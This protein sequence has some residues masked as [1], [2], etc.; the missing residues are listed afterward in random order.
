MSNSDRFNLAIEL[1]DA[2]NREDPTHT[3]VDGIDYPDAL[4]YARRM[5][6]RLGDF[7]P[8]ASEPLRLAAR[9]QHI[10]RWQIPRNRY[11]MT[12]AGYHEWRNDLAKF[13]ATESASLLQQAGYDSETITRVQS[14]LRK[15]QLKSNPDMQTLE[16]VICLV[17]LEFYFSD[18]AKKH[19]EEKLIKIIQRTWKKMSPRGQAAALKLQIEPADRWLIEKALTG[20]TS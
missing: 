20:E 8:N 6:E 7:E 1:F 3:I 14:L 11:P 12:R 19:E 4:L 10:R 17:F 5:T 18:F 13:H 15:E 16:D 2:A 9:C